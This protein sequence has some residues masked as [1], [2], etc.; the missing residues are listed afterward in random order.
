MT[1][2]AMSEPEINSFLDRALR[3]LRAAWGRISGAHENGV[4]FELSPDLG[5]KDIEILVEQMAA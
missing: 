4:M 3:N 1:K 2:K 5:S